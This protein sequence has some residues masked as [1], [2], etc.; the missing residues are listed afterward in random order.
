[1][2][3]IKLDFHIHS[4][5]SPDGNMK[6]KD[7]L[8]TAIS[9]GLDVISVTD[10]NSTKGGIETRNLA[11]K[12]DMPITVFVGQEINTLSGEIIILNLEEDIPQNMSLEETISYGKKGF[13]IAP[14]PFDKFRKGI[15]EELDSIKDRINAIETFNSRTILSSHNKLAEIYARNNKIPGVAGSDS[16]FSEELGSSYFTIESKKTTNSIFKSIKE[17]KISIYGR[18]T[19]LKPHLKTSMIHLFK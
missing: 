11:E 15:G 12:K 17:G 3:K 18:Q 10:H 19:G 7:I 9:K 1:M 13:I 8:E 16:H 2:E 14:H 6:P 5:Y 4:Y